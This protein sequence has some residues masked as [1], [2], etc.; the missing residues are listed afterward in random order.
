MQLNSFESHLKLPLQF[1]DQ[2][3]N[4]KEI[5]DSATMVYRDALAH[6]K[7][8]IMNENNT[9]VED[10]RFIGKEENHLLHDSHHYDLHDSMAYR[11]ACGL[12]KLFLAESTDLGKRVWTQFNEKGMMLGIGILI[13]AWVMAVPLWERGVR[14]EIEFVF[15][16]SGGAFSAE[17]A[18][19]GGREDVK[20]GFKDHYAVKDAE[21]ESKSIFALQPSFW[22]SFQ[23]FR[24]VELAVAFLFMIFQCAV[25]TFG[26]SYIE[27]EREVVLFFL[28]VLCL[29]LFRR[30][31]FASVAQTSMATTFPALG[32]MYLPLVVV[33]CS[34]MNDILVA[35]HGLDPSI[36]LHPAHHSIV[37]LSSLLILAVVR[38]KWMGSSPTAI[39]SHGIVS[40]PLPAL[41]DVLAIVCLAL[42]W[43]EKRARDHSR[44]GYIMARSTM[45]LLFLGLFH[46]FMNIAKEL[47]ASRDHHGHVRGSKWIEL[48]LLGL[49]RVMMFLVILTGPSTG[50]TAVLIVIQCAALCRMMESFGSKEVCVL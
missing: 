42:S 40:I 33:L 14:R 4:L 20:E 36:R 38:I 32:P 1:H 47:K 27:H 22:M 2:L 3:R 37:F 15:F 39:H 28:S 49:F 46:S 10:E 21:N 30:W 25:L 17:D 13:V 6:S 7:K 35:G 45:A 43:W 23:S 48:T 16:G 31:Y 44:N 12:F 8:M 29:L 50:S 24:R 18:G 34:R 11:E 26:N 41:I 9:N 5:L 19:D